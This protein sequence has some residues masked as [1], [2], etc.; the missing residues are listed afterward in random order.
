MST[1]MANK[2][3]IV[4]KWYVLDA[5]GKPLG[6][7]AA[8]AANLLRGK[9]KPEYTPHADC[10]DFVIIINAE[11]AVLTG[12]KLEQKYYRTHSGWIGGLKEVQYSTLMR[13]RPELAMK[14]AVRGMM[15]R[16]VI[17]K[18]SMSRLKIYRGGE[19]EHAAQKPELWAL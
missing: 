2:G 8:A 1:F 13:E 4:R 10:G 11:K 7:T 3:N 6:K 16:N 14:L 19:H 12:K 5:A 18:D 17:S 15:P 9:L